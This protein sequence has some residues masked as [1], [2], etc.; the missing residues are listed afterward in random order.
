[1]TS[2]RW[3]WQYPG[4]KPWTSHSRDARPFPSRGCRD[5]FPLPLPPELPPSYTSQRHIAQR[6]DRRRK[7]VEVV[8][9]AVKSL[10]WLHGTPGADTF[11]ADNLQHEVLRRC[12]HLANLAAARPSDGPLPTPEATLRALLKGRGEYHTSTSPVAV[13]P[14]KLERISVPESLHGSPDAMSLLDPEARRYLGGEEHM[15]KENLEEVEDIKPY[16]DPRLTSDKRGYKSL[17]QMLERLGY[18]RYTLRPKAHVGVFFVWKSDG[19]KIRLIL[20]A[21]SANRMFRDPPGVELCTAEGFSRIEVSVPEGASPGSPEFVEALEGMGLHFGLSDVRDCFHRLRCPEWLSE[22]FCLRPVPAHWVKMEGRMVSGK[23]LDRGDLIYPMAGSFPMGFSWSLFVAQRVNELQIA[24]VPSL[25]N[26]RLMSDRGEPVVFRDPRSCEEMQVRH[27][28]YVDNLGVISPHEGIVRKTLSEL[29]QAFDQEGLILHPGEIQHETVKALGCQLRGDILATRITPERFHK[30][31]LSIEAVLRRKKVSGQVLEI[32][33][34]HATFCALTNRQLLSVFHTVYRY[35]RSSYYSPSILW[36]SVREELEAFKGLMIFLQADWWRPWNTLVSCSDSST[37]GF[38]VSTSFWSRDTVAR[39]G[40][41]CERSRFRKLGAHSAR[42]SALTAA[43]FVQDSVTGKWIVG[44]LD[45]SEYLKASGWELNTSFEEIP[46]E[47]L[48]KEMWQPKL[49]GKW[50]FKEGI[51]CLEGRA[52]VKSLKRIALTVFGQNIRQLLLVDNMSVALAFDRC[53]SRDYF[54]LKQIRKF[55]SYLLAR[56][57]HACVRWLPSELNNSDE[58]SRYFSDEASKLLT[59]SIPHQCHGSKAEDSRVETSPATAPR[60]IEEP[61]ASLEPTSSVG[62]FKGQASQEAGALKPSELQDSLEEPCRDQSLQLGG[63]FAQTTFLAEKRK[64]R[65]CQRFQH[66]FNAEPREEVQEEK[67]SSPPSSAACSSNSRSWNG[68]GLRDF[69]KNFLGA[70]CC[71]ERVSGAVPDSP[72]RVSGVCRAKRPRHHQSRE[73]GPP[74]GRL[75]EQDVCRRPPSLSCRSVG[76]C[77][78]ACLSGVWEA[79]ESKDTSHLASSQRLPEALPGQV[80]ESLPLSDMG[81]V[82]C[83]VG[84]AGPTQN[85]N[86][87]AGVGQLLCPAQRAYPSF[88]PLLGEAF[89]EHHSVLEPSAV[90]RRKASSYQNGGIRHVDPPGLSMDVNMGAKPVLSFE[91]GTSR[92]ETVGL[93][94]RRLR[95]GFSQSSRSSGLGGDPISDSAQRSFNRSCQG[96]QDPSRSSEARTVEKSQIRGPVRES[97]QTCLHLGGSSRRPTSSLSGLRGKPWGLPAQA[98]SSSYFSRFVRQPGRYVMDLFSGEGGVAKACVQLGFK[99][100]MWDLVHGAD[101]DLTCPQV[102]KR[103]KS[104]IRQNR[105]LAVM[106]APVCTSF[107]VARDRTKVI[108]TKRNPWGIHTRL[109]TAE[110]QQKVKTGNEVFLTCFDIIEECLHY[111]IPFI[112]ENP[113]T[114]KAWNLPP[115]QY[116]LQHPRIHFVRSDVCQWGTRWKK[117]TGFLIGNLDH[118]DTARLAQAICTNC[119]R[120]LCSRTGKPHFLLSGSNSRGVPYTRIA[121]AYPTRLSQQLAY[122]LTCPYHTTYTFG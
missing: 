81:W 30:V 67:D 51:I 79:W 76:C 57:I 108:R 4:A 40:H 70:P 82:G 98:T 101:H 55:C 54:L 16:W 58:P 5:L 44:E 90:P 14:F 43:G 29:P 27:Y 26:S 52:L 41:V 1:M 53:R 109:L 20:D 59:D 104:E 93:Q 18:L 8:R 116:Y 56:N 19:Q 114:S 113:Y 31:R 106:M 9:D 83:P 63:C 60:E 107:S 103:L 86:F 96:I 95:K 117:P 13:A 110:E 74:V 78:D 120:G 39:C 11:E 75:H 3:A 25:A 48:R 35:I 10:N 100:K 61:K 17:I 47:L 84:T 23:K 62:I 66:K 50:S 65:E 92:P 91:R 115:M 77:P 80:Q 72:E 38:G 32:V 2:G 69:S 49:W 6:R 73:S 68:D 42:D 71:E 112:L 7:E 94:L 88:D 111:G 122:I 102:K 99:A 15:L 34:G 97:S 119:P 24:K 21:R 28:V 46:A 85:G 121:Q 33:I 64:A 12:F 89:K 87:S 22:Y 37:T 45:S 118:N 36:N 105:V